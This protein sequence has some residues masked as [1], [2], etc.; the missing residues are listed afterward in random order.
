VV[1]HG[2]ERQLEEID[3]ETEL[4]LLQKTKDFEDVLKTPAGRRMLADIMSIAGIDDDCFTGNSQ[5]YY[6]LG[7]RSIALAI[8][9]MIKAT[10]NAAWIKME[11]EAEARNER[12]RGREER[13]AEASLD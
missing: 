12:V 6:L 8:K 9:K 5:T 4:Y 11:Q 10:S 7:R 3:R 2:N 13:R 1:E